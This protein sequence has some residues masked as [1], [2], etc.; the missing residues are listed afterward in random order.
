MRWERSHKQELLDSIERVAPSADGTTRSMRTPAPPSKAV[1]EQMADALRYVAQLEADCKD[2]PAALLRVRALR[3]IAH[4]TRCEP[5]RALCNQVLELST[6][7]PADRRRRLNVDL[8]A[9]VDAALLE[10]AA[11]G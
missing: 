5:L 2:W 7:P 11:R 8:A 4:T 10:L 9:A 3:G 6:E 1:R